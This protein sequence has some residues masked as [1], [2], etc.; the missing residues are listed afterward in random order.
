MIRMSEKPINAIGEIFLKF[1]E[2]L[3]RELTGRAGKT[4]KINIAMVLGFIFLTIILF[5]SEHHFKYIYPSGDHSNY[6]IIAIICTT[7]IGITSLYAI[8]SIEKTEK[9]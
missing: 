6:V 1:F 8:Y 3:C 7:V 9:N 4:G 5:V 2:I